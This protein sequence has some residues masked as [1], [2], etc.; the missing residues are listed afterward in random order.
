MTPEQRAA[1]LITQAACAVIEALSIGG[2]QIPGSAGQ[3]ILRLLD[4][5]GIH[6]NAVV[7]FLQGRL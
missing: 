5:Y 1:Y 4:K 2:N 3:E 6:H 7:S